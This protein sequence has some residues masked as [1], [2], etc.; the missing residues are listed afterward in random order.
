MTRAVLFD[1]DDTLVDFRPTDAGVLFDAGAARIYAC[2]STLECSLPTYEQFCRRQRGI[3]RRIALKRRLT[4]TQPDGRALLR[5]LCRDYRLQRDESS[6][7]RLGWLWYE[8]VAETASV[9]DDVIPTLLALRH[10]GIKLGIVANTTFQGAVIDRHLDSLGLLE[11]FPVRAYST[12]H[13][14][15]KPHAS[16][17]NAALAELDVQPADAIYVGDTFSTDIVGGNRAG[18]RTVLKHPRPSARAFKQSNHVIERLGQLTDL[19]EIDAAP[20]TL[21]LPPLRAVG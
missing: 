2:L 19:L 11:F 15:A 21:S 7:A 14:V 4:F 6:L 12:E 17:F 8:P 18:L 3:A 13:G 16:L 9:A 5:R 1:L 10:A 20:S